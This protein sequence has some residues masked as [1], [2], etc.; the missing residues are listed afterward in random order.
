M[1]RIVAVAV[2]GVA[3]L[4]AACGPE[5]GGGPPNPNPPP[6]GTAPAA[7]AAVFRPGPVTLLT[8]TGT[9]PSPLGALEVDVGEKVFQRWAALASRATSPSSTPRPRRSSFSPSPTTPA[10]RRSPGS[11]TSTTGCSSPSW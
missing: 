9:A 4:L 10:P 11:A 5:L 8:V 7:E 3:L 1:R 2:A 6:D